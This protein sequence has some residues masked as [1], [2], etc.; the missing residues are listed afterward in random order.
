[1]SLVIKWPLYCSKDLWLVIAYRL[2]EAL[3]FFSHT[4]FNFESFESALTTMVP[5]LAVMGALSLAVEIVSAILR[6]GSVVPN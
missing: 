4:G 1:M 6:L 2:I 5:L 3:I